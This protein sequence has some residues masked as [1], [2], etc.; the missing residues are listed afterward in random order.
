[1]EETE[2][3]CITQN[4][5]DFDAK[6]LR[7]PWTVAVMMPSLWKN[8]VGHRTSTFQ[9]ERSSLVWRQLVG[10]RRTVSMDVGLSREQ[11]KLQERFHLH[12]EGD[13]NGSV[14]LPRL[15]NGPLGARLVPC[16]GPQKAKSLDA[17]SQ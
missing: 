15:T 10:S 6:H 13:S 9:H 4:P 12:R 1:M 14:G 2:E 5:H 7:R 3:I 16:Y 11:P 17:T 8:Q